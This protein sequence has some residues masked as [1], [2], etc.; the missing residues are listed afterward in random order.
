MNESQALK[1]LVDKY[2]I[3]KVRRVMDQEVGYRPAGTF[4]EMLTSTGPVELS[5][6]GYRAG[7]HSKL[8]AAA[9]NPELAPVAVDVVRLLGEYYARDLEVVRALDQ[10]AGKNPSLRD[11]VKEAKGRLQRS[12]PLSE[13]VMYSVGLR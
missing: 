8:I 7:E 2:G 11:G 9:R 5:I 1:Q 10:I 4:G 6:G 12:I 13:R 3:D